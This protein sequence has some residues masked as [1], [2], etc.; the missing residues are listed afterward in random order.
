MRRLTGTEI[1]LQQYRCDV[2]GDVE[3]AFEI[4][5]ATQV[6]NFAQLGNTTRLKFP[7]TTGVR[8]F[9]PPRPQRIPKKR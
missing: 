6:K 5:I 2:G 9:L 1:S 4:V 3:V 8:S 7:R